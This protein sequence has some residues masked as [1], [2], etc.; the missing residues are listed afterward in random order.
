MNARREDEGKQNAKLVRSALLNEISN[1]RALFRAR[2]IFGLEMLSKRGIS[3][4]EV[5]T[6]L[7]E[8]VSFDAMA[9]A[10]AESAGRNSL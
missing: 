5:P 2:D 4:G 3:R 7:I 10:S 9:P 6:R 1:L 8:C